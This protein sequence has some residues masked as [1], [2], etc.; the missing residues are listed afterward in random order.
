[1]KLLVILL[2]LLSERFLIHSVSYQRFYWFSDYCQKIRINAAKHNAFSNPWV[3]L[4]LIILP[5]LLLVSLIY[6]LLYPFLFGFMGFLLSLFIFFY[7]LGPQNLFYPI[8]QSDVKTNEDLV[9]DYFVLVNTQ[10]FSLVF[11][12]VIAGPIGALLYRLITLSRD[13][14]F[15][16]EQAKEVTDLLEWIPSRL[17]VLLFL[18]VGNFQR[19]FSLFNGYIFAKPDVNGMMLRECGLLAL[20]TSD[21][22]EVTMREA[23]SLVEHAII[24]MLVFIA[25]FTLIT[26]L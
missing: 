26:W 5:I 6:I 10:L 23:E 24:V 2:S 21:T 18:I 11:W 22:Q 3:L 17:T 4:S 20:R 15:V 19:S 12:F 13:I 9:G 8:I 25:L 7:C 14:N 16:S 1:M